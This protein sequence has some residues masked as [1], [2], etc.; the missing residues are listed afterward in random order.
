MG[1]ARPSLCQI[2]LR[3]N[4]KSRDFVCDQPVQEHAE[5]MAS[6]DTCVQSLLTC[7]RKHESRQELV[8]LN[9]H[10]K[11]KTTYKELFHC[12]R[13]SS[14]LAWTTDV[15]MLEAAIDMKIPTIALVRSGMH[16]E[17]LE[18]AVIQTI[19]KSER[20]TGAKIQVT[21]EIPSTTRPTEAPQEKKDEKKD[22]GGVAELFAPT[23]DEDEEGES[24][25]EGPSPM[26]SDDQEMEDQEMSDA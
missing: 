4:A 17:L 9:L 3:Y 18:R 25:E 21:R 20:L 7:H 19:M 2:L 11:H 15:F 10:A 23:E 14:L 1:R 24:G 12:L 13:L 5:E 26:G 8:A 22:V 16:G 6:E